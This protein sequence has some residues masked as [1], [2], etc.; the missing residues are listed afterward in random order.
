VSDLTPAITPSSRKAALRR[1]VLAARHGL[2]PPERRRADATLAAALVPLVAG[3]VV[4]GHV[5]IAEE[6][7]G[8]DLLPALA[9]AA[10]LLL[11]V[12]LPD[13]DL[14]WARY[15][16]DLVPGGR[17]LREP[18]GP[19]LGVAAIADA[20]LIV[21]PAVAVDRRGIRLGRGGGSYDRALARA[22]G[23]V[24]AVLYPDDLVDEVPTEPHDRPVD[25]VLT[26]DGLWTVGA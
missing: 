15:E 14:D 10:R 23:R 3:R 25:A 20:E 12:L 22:T 17:G 4:A 5:P 24:I 11:P 18:P 1:A 8:A 9:T 2:P 7:G 6:P 21:A 16:G 19:R 13:L 26:P